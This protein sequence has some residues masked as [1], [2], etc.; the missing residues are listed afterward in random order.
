MLFRSL[1]QTRRAHAPQRRIPE[2]NKKGFLGE[3]RIAVSY[4]SA[5]EVQHR[6][7]PSPK[8]FFP[9][10]LIAQ[11]RGAGL[12]RAAPG[13]EV[14]AKSTDQTAPP[15]RESH[16]KIFPFLFQKEKPPAPEPRR[17]KSFSFPFLKKGNPPLRWETQK[18]PVPRRGTEV[19][20]RS[21]Q[22]QK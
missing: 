20:A 7:E 3:R 10:F 12:G 4:R 15:R 22:H 8:R 17:T 9:P 5:A 16:K 18:A 13:L 1:V 2:K 21:G 14:N 6:S 11:K 19:S